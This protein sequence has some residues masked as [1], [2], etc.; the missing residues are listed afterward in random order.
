MKNK[1]KVLFK[2]LSF[3]LPIII[4]IL[5]NIVK[6][7]GF[8]NVMKLP[9]VD[10]QYIPLLKYLKSVLLF[11]N[12][13]MYSF[14]KSLGG[15]MF[16]TYFYYLS[17]PINI[18]CILFKNI[19]YETIN[20]I[21]K[22]KIGLCGMMT[23]IFLGSKA[24]KYLINFVFS[25]C[26]ALMGY[27]IIYAHNVMW[28]DV[29]YITP[30]VFLGIDLLIKNDDWRLY[31]FSLIYAIMCNFYIAF[32]LCIFSFIYTLYNLLIVLDKNR[33][34]ILKKF[35]FLS[36][37]IGGICAL[38]LI[39]ISYELINLNDR[40]VMTNLISYDL[41]NLPLVLYKGLVGSNSLAFYSIMNVDAPNIYCSI[42]VVLLNLF[43]LFC[44]DVS[45]KEKIVIIVIEL[46]FILSMVFQPLYLMWHCFST[47]NGN[48]YRFSFL[49]CFF[50][51]FIAYKSMMKIYD[52]SNFNYKKIFLVSMIFFLLI[53]FSFFSKAYS[54][55]YNGTEII[56]SAIFCFLYVIL[57][58]K[59]LINY[60]LLLLIFELILN[61]IQ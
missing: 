10:L 19:S 24:D 21:K 11:D 57:I 25:L 48:P 55:F 38:F 20:V 1:N 35:L 4:L 34:K 12:S 27:N 59:K 15:S 49:W 60:V 17:S 33:I 16:A 28:F 61:Y 58:K 18:I 56:I 51:I 31:T 13:I 3:L 6:G 14:S 46:F 44:Y 43:Y 40:F 8:S 7:N 45:K 39:P 9:D 26:Y 41:N 36:L 30:I 5:C 32:S 42:L 53:I 47:T 54:Y 29:V 2:M 22:I 52:N 50:H 37:F 23:Y